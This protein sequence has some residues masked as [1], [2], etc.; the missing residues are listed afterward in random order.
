MAIKRER[1]RQTEQ[2]RSVRQRGHGD[3]RL[4]AVVK[5]SFKI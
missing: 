2:G 4:M 3:V 5:E 1:E